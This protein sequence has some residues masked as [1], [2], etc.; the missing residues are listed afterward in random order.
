MAIGEKQHVPR[1]GRRGSGDA[2]RR[3]WLGAFHLSSGSRILDFAE[4]AKHRGRVVDIG[5]CD[6]RCDQ[7]LGVSGLSYLPNQ[8]YT[9]ES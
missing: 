5:T 7:W 2:D 6:V 8:A 4:H 1:L 9:K 3:I